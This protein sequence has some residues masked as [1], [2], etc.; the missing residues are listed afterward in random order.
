MKYRLL[1]ALLLAAQPALAGDITYIIQQPSDMVA[2]RQWYA[3]GKGEPPVPQPGVNCP[4]GSHWCIWK[5][6]G[7]DLTLSN[8]RIDDKNQQIYAPSE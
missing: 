6:V 5:P 4:D 7:G 3:P 2:T 1:I 8:Y